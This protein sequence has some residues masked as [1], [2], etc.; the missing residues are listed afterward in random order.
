MQKSKHESSTS[1]TEVIIFMVK[2]YKNMMGVHLKIRNYFCTCLNAMIL[3]SPI[4]PRRGCACLG[5]RGKQRESNGKQEQKGWNA[6]SSAPIYRPKNQS[7]HG[8]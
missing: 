6:W 7:A 2:Q 1:T 4:K 3:S 5:R 8:C